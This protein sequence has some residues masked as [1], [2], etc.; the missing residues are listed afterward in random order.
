[1]GD[2]HILVWKLNMELEEGTK[3]KVVQE[4]L[5]SG[6][7]LNSNIKESQKKLRDELKEL[8]ISGEEKE[9]VNVADSKEILAQLNKVNKNVETLTRTV[10]LMEKRISLVEEQVKLL[11]KNDN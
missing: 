7:A 10:L 11:S 6:A 1:M 3:E 5:R 9:N 8:K 2:N 4:V